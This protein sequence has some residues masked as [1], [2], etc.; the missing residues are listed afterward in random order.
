MAKHIAG[1]AAKIASK[2]LMAGYIG[3]ELN[4]GIRSFGGSHSS[5]QNT[6][7]PVNTLDV[8]KIIKENMEKQREESTTTGMEDVKIMLYI[9]AAIVV[10]IALIHL[11]M[12]MFSTAKRNAEIE[13]RH[14]LETRP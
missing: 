7:P 4:D 8:V 5:T 13:M 3:Y 1:T 6:P 12:K 9:I 10:V 14:Y 2:Y 11:L